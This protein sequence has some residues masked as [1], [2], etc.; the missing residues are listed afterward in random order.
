MILTERAGPDS[1]WRRPRI[2]R[3]FMFIFKRLLQNYRR[4]KQLNNQTF[5]VST[6][7]YYIHVYRMTS[8]F[9][10]ILNTCSEGAKCCTW[11]DQTSKKQII[12][13]SVLPS[14]NESPAGRPA[15]QR[16]VHLSS[17]GRHWHPVF[18]LHTLSALQH[19]NPSCQVSTT[20]RQFFFFSPEDFHFFFGCWI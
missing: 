14:W 7:F 15:V 5:N 18:Y 10:E 6:S 11:I 9:T 20:Q 4:K 17:E 16:D 12:R 8:K 13:P 19:H 3:I 2:C 1:T